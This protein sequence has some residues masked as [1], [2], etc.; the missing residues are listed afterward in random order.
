MEFHG[1]TTMLYQ[2]SQGH[3][4]IVIITLTLPSLLRSLFSQLDSNILEDGRAFIRFDLVL[5]KRLA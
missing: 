3:L 1:V 2:G 4:M 5:T